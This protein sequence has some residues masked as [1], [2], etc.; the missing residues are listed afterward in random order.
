[1]PAI[2]VFYSPGRCKNKEQNSWC[3]KKCM[4]IQVD[5]YHP[6]FLLQQGMSLIQKGERWMLERRH[7]VNYSSLKDGTF[8]SKRTTPRKGEMIIFGLVLDKM[9]QN[10][11]K[12]KVLANFRPLL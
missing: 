11:P 12:L 1:M 8:V 6:L 9:P 10:T 4:Q 3:G 7:P 2:F 5:F